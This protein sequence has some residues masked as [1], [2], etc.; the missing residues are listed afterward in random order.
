MLVFVIGCFLLRGSC[1]HRNYCAHN[2]KIDLFVLVQATQ[3]YKLN[4]IGVGF[5]DEDESDE[6]GEEEPEAGGQDKKAHTDSSGSKTDTRTEM[7]KDNE[8][9]LRKIVQRL[10][11]AAEVR[12]YNRRQNI[13]LLQSIFVYAS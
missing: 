13:R 8:N 6:E 5:Q 11:P 12:E 4:I 2:L 9:L 1:A 10:Q 7:Q 3:G